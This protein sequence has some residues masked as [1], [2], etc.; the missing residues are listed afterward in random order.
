MEPLLAHEAAEGE[1]GRVGELAGAVGHAVT[2]GK[3]RESEMM[4]VER[5][6]ERVREREVRTVRIKKAGAL[7]R[8]E[9]QASPAA[10]GRHSFRA[11]PAVQFSDQNT[12]HCSAIIAHG[13]AT[14]PLP[15]PLH[16]HNCPSLLPLPLPPPPLSAGRCSCNVAVQRTVSATPQAA[17]LLF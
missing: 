12:Q 2:G 16:S 5:T 15:P 6:R 9:G 4:G 7:T 13:A 1:V 11:G 8:R 17:R 10:P 14:P 3:G